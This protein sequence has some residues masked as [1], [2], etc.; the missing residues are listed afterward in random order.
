[1]SHILKEA[2]ES[3][4]KDAELCIER[5]DVIGCGLSGNKENPTDLATFRRWFRGD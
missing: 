5:F 4:I 1:M 3:V 2:D